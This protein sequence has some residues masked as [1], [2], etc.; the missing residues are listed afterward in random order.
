MIAPQ[1]DGPRG[2]QPVANVVKKNQTHPLLVSPRA[3]VEPAPPE[4]LPLRQLGLRLQYLAL[5]VEQ[6]GLFLLWQPYHCQS[7]RLI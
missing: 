2:L 4:R 5:A 7:R 6:F 1:V 3:K